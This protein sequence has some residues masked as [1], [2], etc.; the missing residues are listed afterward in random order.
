MIPIYFCKSS[1]TTL[2]G[3]QSKACAIYNF[4]YSGPQVGGVSGTGCDFNG[5]SYANIV[6]SGGS[7]NTACVIAG[8]LTPTT[9]F[10]G[11]VTITF[12]SNCTS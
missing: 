4:S 8:S 1:T 2:T 6:A 7:K 3:N 5:T 11:T 9:P 12:V 10:G